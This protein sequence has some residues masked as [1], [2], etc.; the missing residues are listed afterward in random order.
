MHSC[1]HYSSVLSADIPADM[2]LS[3]PLAG[4]VLPLLLRIVLNSTSRDASVLGRVLAPTV[5]TVLHVCGCDA[6]VPSVSS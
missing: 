6:C 5:V 2:L 4:V 3:N 1:L